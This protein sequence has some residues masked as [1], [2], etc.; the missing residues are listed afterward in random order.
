MKLSQLCDVVAERGYAAKATC[1]AHTVLIDDGGN[2]E[3]SGIPISAL[4]SEE[5]SLE[6][7]RSLLDWAKLAKEGKRDITVKRLGKAGTVN[8]RYIR[9]IDN[10]SL[11]RDDGEK[12]LF[13]SMF[14][15]ANWL[16][17]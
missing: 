7:A 11:K 12:K 1:G 14:R 9:N 2:L 6:G 15:N 3:A 10:V 8:L 13:L 16:E 4:E 17:V 5:W